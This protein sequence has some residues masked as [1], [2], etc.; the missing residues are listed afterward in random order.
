MISNVLTL[1][2]HNSWQVYLGLAE[3]CPQSTKWMLF[4]E[5][6][7][8]REPKVLCLLF[9]EPGGSWS[10][11]QDGDGG[12]LQHLRGWTFPPTTVRGGPL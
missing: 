11:A 12:H 10:L 4:Q 9:P 1:K 3:L 5:T 6:G 8:H 7:Q 2:S